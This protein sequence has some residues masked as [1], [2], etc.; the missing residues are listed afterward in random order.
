MTLYLKIYEQCR[1][2]KHWKH[3][4]L[5][6]MKKNPYMIVLPIMNKNIQLRYFLSLYLLE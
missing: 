4:K 6:L 1:L 2:W 5:N 3:Y